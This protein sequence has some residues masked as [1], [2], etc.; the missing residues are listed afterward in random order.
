MIFTAGIIFLLLVLSA[1]F[2]AAEMSLT[3]ASRSRMHALERQGK[4]QAARV[5]KLRQNM[6]QVIG[7]ILI[8]N[9]LLN[10]L[11]SALATN[12]LIT[13]FDEGGVI[14]ATILMTF[15]VVV[16]GEML[17]KTIA[18]NNADRMAL[19][20]SRV[21]QL[22]TYLLYP[23]TWLT[24]KFLFGLQGILHLN[25]TSALGSQIAQEELRGAI[26]LHASAVT[27]QPRQTGAMLH[28][29]LDLNK[30]QVGSI[31]MHRRNLT[32]ID[33]DQPIGQIID[34]VVKSPHTRIPLWRDNPDNVIGV[35]H[36]RSLL[37]ALQA[38]QGRTE[39]IDL[40]KIANRPWFIPFT[41]NLLS[42]LQAFRSRR[43]HFALVVDEYGVLMGIVTLEDILEEIVGN[44]EDET[45]INVA[46][47]RA[48][49]DG[50]YLVDGQ[51]TLR[52]LNREF[53]WRL[54]DMRTSTIAGLVLH[55][56]RRIPDKGQVFI[57]HG[58][59]FEVLDMLRYQIKTL[60]ITPVSFLEK[61]LSETNQ[62]LSTP[63]EHYN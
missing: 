36:A 2:S 51:V 57:F 8:C 49:T 56:A 26:D 32:M 52:D 3:A 14:Y 18:I 20:V 24:N 48:Q 11:A 60:R 22:I 40:V 42:Q 25:H 41:T 27:S 19:A 46:G 50:S 38:N 5:N 31:M 55:E 61:S 1:F 44:I 59:R 7:S 17:P 45:D 29:I 30:V 35:L 23:F 4:K 62:E 39:N 16:F 47:V 53:N 13:S 21:I 15:L 28:S 9:N 33:I 10:I 37:H 58:L 54:P 63:S 34:L 6:E 12:L 43:E